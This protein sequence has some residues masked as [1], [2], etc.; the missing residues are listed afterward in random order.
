MLRRQRVILKRL[1][2][3]VERRT[4]DGTDTAPQTWMERAWNIL[5]QRPHESNKLYVLYAPEVECIGM[6]KTH[7]PFEFGVKVSMA[8]THKSGLVVGSRSFPGNPYDGHT[9]A[10]QIDLTPSLLQDLGVKPTAAAVD[11][12]YRGVD[13]LAPVNI[14]HRVRSKTKTNQQRRWLK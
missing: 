12:G 9:L 14:I 7:Q 2:H 1:L 4:T 8:V 13:H 5:R 10:S 6:C 11:S 3:D